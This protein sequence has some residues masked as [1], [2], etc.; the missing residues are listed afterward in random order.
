MP[1]MDEPSVGLAPHVVGDM[2]A[3]IGALRAAGFTILLGGQTLGVATA[4]ADTA[5]VLQGG[6]I[7]HPG[8]AAGLLDDQE[9]LRSDLG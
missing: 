8:P 7:V 3:A 5:H 6:R 9:V 2:V 4:V 1:L